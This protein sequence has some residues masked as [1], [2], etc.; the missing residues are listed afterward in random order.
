MCSRGAMNTKK[1]DKTA[2]GLDYMVDLCVTLPK[3]GRG[4]R[5]I[6]GQ[7]NINILTQEGLGRKDYVP[8][9][10][11]E[12]LSLGDRHSESSLS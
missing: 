8:V 1:T 6:L 3:A 9:V 11:G 12:S 4:Q 2:Q 5:T 7:G 10:K